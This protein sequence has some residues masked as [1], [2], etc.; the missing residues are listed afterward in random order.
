MVWKG[1]VVG[2]RGR[3]P[4]GFSGPWATDG[5]H[6]AHRP[7]LFIAGFVLMRLFLRIGAFAL[8]VQIGVVASFFAQAK[9]KSTGNA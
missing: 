7:S 4:R 8:I 2:E 3:R 5:G 1:E 9:P 6:A